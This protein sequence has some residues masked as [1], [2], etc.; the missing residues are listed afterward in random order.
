MS[1]KTSRLRLDNVRVV[2][3]SLDKPASFAG[4]TEE[5]AKYGIK[6]LVPKGD[7]A[8]IDNIKAFL[9]ANVDNVDKWSK[10]AK[11]QVYKT[12]IDQDPY[13]DNCV[14]KDG[15][16]INA[17]RL[18]EEKEAVAAYEGHIVIGANR[19][20]KKGPPVV[21]DRNN[22]PIDKGLI[23]GEIV[24]GYWVNAYVDAYCYNKPKNGITLS[25]Y[26]VQ[27]VKEDEVFGQPSPFDVVEGDDEEEDEPTF[28]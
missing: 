23:A 26:A 20:Q 11:A 13:N 7:K 6:F 27:K 21:V 10:T 8:V 12:A 1:K 3:P 19:N 22:E 18:D 2:Y 15:D 17:R 16:K 25:L 24:S 28:G 9:K 4:Q 14:I 5:Q